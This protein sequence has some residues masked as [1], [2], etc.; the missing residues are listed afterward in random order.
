MFFLGF[1]IDDENYIAISINATTANPAFSPEIVQDVDT[2]R[3]VP[4]WCPSSLAKLV[5][6]STFT[7]VYGRYI[8]IYGRDW[9]IP[10][11]IGSWRVPTLVLQRIYK[12]KPS[13]RQCPCSGWGHM[14][15]YMY[16]YIHITMVNKL[17]VETIHRNTYTTIVTGTNITRRGTT[18]YH[19]PSPRPSHLQSPSQHA[20]IPPGVQH[21]AQRPL[22]AWTRWLLGRSLLGVTG[23]MFISCLFGPNIFWNIDYWC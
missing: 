19:V 14:S 23:L 18:L 7:T 4:W 2:Y 9:C 8:Y 10:D 15:I 21:Q 16:I 20:E 6:N 1:L 11:K 3:V 13:S 17:Y 22:F 5:Y 12:K